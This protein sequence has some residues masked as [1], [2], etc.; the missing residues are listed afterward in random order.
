MRE[1][2]DAM[3]TIYGELA[4]VARR[5]GVTDAEERPLLYP[6]MGRKT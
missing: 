4:A 1:L 6:I 5:A 3:L 2:I